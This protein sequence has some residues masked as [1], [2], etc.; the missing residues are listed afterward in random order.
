MKHTKA[1]VTLLEDF[2]ARVGV[3]LLDNVHLGIIPEVYLAAGLPLHSRE[4]GEF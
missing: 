1:I 4:Y 2:N 3:S